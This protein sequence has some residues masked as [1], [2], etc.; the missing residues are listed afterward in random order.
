M[1][2]ISPE[3]A[4]P[5]TS[6]S[7]R[8]AHLVFRDT[9]V[10]FAFTDQ[11]EKEEVAALSIRDVVQLESDLRGITS[12]VDRM[13][14]LRQND[15]N[16]A[17]FL[18]QRL[19]KALEAI[20]PENKAA[21]LQAQLQ[22]PHLVND[23][24]R[25]LIF[26]D[27]DD[28]NPVEAAAR[29]V[30]Y[31]QIR[32]KCFGA[33]RAFLPMTLEGA[34]RGQE[35]VLRRGLVC[36]LPVRDAAGRAIVM[37]QPGRR[38]FDVISP[39]QEAMAKFYIMEAALEDPEVRKRGIVV[40]VNGRGVEKRHYNLYLMRLLT[41]VCNCVPFHLRALHLCHPSAVGYYVLFP[42][43][44]SFVGKHIRRRFKIHRGTDE[45]IV[46]ILDGFRLP[47]RCVPVDL[48]GDLQVDTNAFIVER[49]AKER[50]IINT[51]AAAAAAAA[52]A[53]CAPAAGPMVVPAPAA[54][55]PAHVGLVVGHDLPIAHAQGNFA[56]ANAVPNAKRIR[57]DH[58]GTPDS[59]D[60]NI[61][62]NTA[63]TAT[64]GTSGTSRTSASSSSTATKP[65]GKRMTY[66]D[67]RMKKAVELRLANPKMKLKDALE[68]GGFVFGVLDDA[69]E[70]VDA[71]DGVR[72]TQ[73]KNQLSRRLRLAKQKKGESPKPSQQYCEKNGEPQPQPQQLQAQLQAQNQVQQ[74]AQ[75][76]MQ[77][78]LNPQ[79][80][81]Q[82]NLVPGIGQFNSLATGSL[83]PMQLSPMPSPAL[84]NH[85][86]Y[87][88][89]GSNV[90]DG[91]GETDPTQRAIG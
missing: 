74:P 65:T 66:A 40:L 49:L 3:T 39:E 34:M 7:N 29:F 9:D 31:W 22:C 1:Q 4:A 48:G 42:V 58:S 77:Q 82:Q 63:S 41:S 18:L 16:Q 24:D 27:R 17:A 25:R 32:L 91:N 86:N 51:T 73:R 61:T 69:G 15:A 71:G 55:S 62:A 60:T 87:L 72:L 53:A 35:S 84:G 54:A 2:S 23:P 45:E 44:K 52:A 6:C 37:L 12:G 20:P 36:L 14:I 88:L 67:D 80:M 43:L 89:G 30:D 78:Q 64:S 59:V 19:D 57:T 90:T 46:M 56:V 83:V 75:V 70:E 68:Q 21:Y 76:Q 10:N 5:D 13:S 79:A 33:H 85:L 50:G 81:G 8:P 47:K 38:D 11:A 28:N 26:L